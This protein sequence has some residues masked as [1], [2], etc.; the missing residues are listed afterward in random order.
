M[1]VVA[2]PPRS[3]SGH[4][5]EAQE[6]SFLAASAATE[7]L[8]RQCCPVARNGWRMRSPRR[9]RCQIYAA[10]QLTCLMPGSLW[11]TVHNVT[12]RNWLLRQ[13]MPDVSL[14]RLTP[15]AV[16]LATV[17]TDSNKRVTPSRPN[18]LAPLIAPAP[19]ACRS[20]IQQPQCFVS[21]GGNHCI[22]YRRGSD[23]PPLLSLPAAAPDSEA[24]MSHRCRRLHQTILMLTREWSSL[25]LS[26][27]RQGSFIA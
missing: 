27:I 22:G 1:P 17:D 9:R 19:T 18:W 21:D 11:L 3:S 12:P 2:V 7:R 6:F 5:P 13:H 23:D 20:D 15:P 10:D 8:H 16:H 26:V 24:K 14:V 4:S 25:A